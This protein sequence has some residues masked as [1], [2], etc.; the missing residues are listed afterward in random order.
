[1]VYIIKDQSLYQIE[2]RHTK[3]EEESR[4]T[5]FVST[6]PARINLQEGEIQTNKVLIQAIHF[7]ECSNPDGN[8]IE[9]IRMMT[10]SGLRS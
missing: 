7:P 8:V 2:I 6:P 9:M 1:M 10:I 4:K 5:V 3:V